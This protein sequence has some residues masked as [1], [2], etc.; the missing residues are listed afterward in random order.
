MSRAIAFAFVMTIAFSFGFSSNAQAATEAGATDAGAGIGGAFGNF[1][2]VIERGGNKETPA[3]KA[4]PGVANEEAEAAAKAA[5]DDAA[6]QEWMK[7]RLRIK[8]RLTGLKKAVERGGSNMKTAVEKGGSNVK[9]AVEKGGSNVVTAVER[10][11]SSEAAKENAAAP[12]HQ[13][14]TIPPNTETEVQPVGKWM[15][16]FGSFLERGGK[17]E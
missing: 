9:T 7:R 3:T 14:N 2:K 5:T 8:E 15:S 13:V 16:D 4:A 17:Q 10:G 11:G 1:I 6:E 12:A